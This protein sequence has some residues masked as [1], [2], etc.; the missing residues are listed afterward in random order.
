MPRYRTTK[1]ATFNIKYYK[2]GRKGK[3]GKMMRRGGMKAG[4]QIGP[5][6][7]PSKLILRGNVG[8]VMPDE[9]FCTLKYSTIINHTGVVSNQIFKANSLYDPDGTHSINHQPNGFDQLS[10]FYNRYQVLASK[11]DIYINNN[12]TTIP[13]FVTYGY[14][15]LNPNL[16]NDL[17]F[18]ENPYIKQVAL[19]PSQ[20]LGSFHRTITCSTKKI[21][22]H[23]SILQ[24]ERTWGLCG[25]IGSGS[26]PADFVFGFC[27]IVADD[28]VSSQNVYVRYTVEFTCR[29]FQ[30]FLIPPSKTTGG[31]TGST[32]ATGANIIDG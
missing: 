16:G 15:A 10:L 4:Y 6:N 18:P 30:K 21:L 7:K 9:Y 11:M 24:D 12:S 22:G 2:K 8:A 3:R 26:D 25:G 32:G 20:G 5:M 29:F 1:G 23:K 14:S 28:G 19:G 31:T 27:N 13:C 17:Y